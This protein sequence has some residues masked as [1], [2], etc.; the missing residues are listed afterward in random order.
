MLFQLSNGIA[1]LLLANGRHCQGDAHGEGVSGLD[2]LVQLPL[3]QSVCTAALG[4]CGMRTCVLPTSA[5]LSLVSANLNLI[6]LCCLVPVSQCLWCASSGRCMEYPIRRVLPPADLCE[7]RSARWGVC[8]GK[9]IE[10]SPLC[11]QYVMLF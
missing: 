9:W 11:E 5:A 7:L 2:W 8:W 3:H 6:T 10:E 4:G 1:E